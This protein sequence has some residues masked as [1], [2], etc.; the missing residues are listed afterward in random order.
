[1][2]RLA[3]NFSHAAAELLAAGKI[4]LDRFKTPDWP[5][6]IAAAWK[7][8]PPYVHFALNAGAD[9]SRTTDWDVAVE[10]ARLTKTP[11]INFH[12]AARAKDFPADDSTKDRVKARLLA[13][14]QKAADFF[15][16]NRVIVENIPLGNPDENFAPAGVDPKV[17]SEIIAGTGVGLLLDLSHARL[18]ARHLKIDERE[19][20]SALPVDHLRELHLTGLQWVDGRLRDHMPMGDA[21]WEI[22]GWAFEKIRAGQW[23][24][25]AIVAFE[26]GGVGESFAWRT[27]A[28]AIETQ[29]P[30]LWE[31]VHG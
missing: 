16:R 9:D 28:K 2:M 25:P 13:D 8:L 26:Y 14:V 4:Q 18:T 11:F 15:G 30:R 27:D 19:Y 20:I 29:L 12:L 21:D 17:I 10:L 22:A 1:M 31:M 24:T 3:I 5:E 6:V 23:A 7:Y